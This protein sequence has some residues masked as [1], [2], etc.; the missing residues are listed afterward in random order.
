MTALAATTRGR[1]EAEVVAPV[2][3]SE[4]RIVDNIAHNTRGLVV[5]PPMRRTR[6]VR[7][8]GLTVVLSPRAGGTLSCSC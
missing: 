4:A 2:E 6:P 3:D 1:P 8:G 7:P 5:L